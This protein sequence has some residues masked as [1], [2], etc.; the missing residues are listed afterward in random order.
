MLNKLKKTI[1]YGF[2]GY[3][4]APANLRRIIDSN[5]I[6]VENAAERIGISRRTLYYY[7][8][9]SH[10]SVAPYHVQYALENIVS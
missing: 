5:N 3:N 10:P 2:A 8:D 6:T 1:D 4:P 7:L 9:I